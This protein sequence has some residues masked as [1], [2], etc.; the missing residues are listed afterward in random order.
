M[1]PGHGGV[2]L[3]G[4]GIVV[5]FYWLLNNATAFKQITGTAVTSTGTVAKAFQN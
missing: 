4:I 1:H 3:S 5:V 2:I